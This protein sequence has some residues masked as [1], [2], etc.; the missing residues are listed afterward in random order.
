[1]PSLITLNRMNF[2]GYSPGM[3]LRTEGLTWQE[4]D[5]ELVLLDLNASA[6]LT[7]NRTGAFLAKQLVEERT[8]DE[9]VESMVQEYG[10]DSDVARAD[11][12]EFLDAAREQ[13]LLV[14]G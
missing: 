10:I 6:Y 12:R 4:I 14:G 1:M 11:L 9:L 3:R 2:A 7:T 5:G 13:G 8:E